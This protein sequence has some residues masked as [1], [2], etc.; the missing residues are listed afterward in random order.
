MIQNNTSPRIERKR[1]QR[2]QSLLQSALELIKQDGLAGLT[3]QKLADRQDYAVG[4]LYRYFK[5]KDALLAALQRQILTAFAEVI[6]TADQVFIQTQSD[7]HLEPK[8]QTIE[9]ARA[10][11]RL[12]L[13]SEVYFH[14]PKICPQR[15]RLLYEMTFSPQPL[16]GLHEG[17]L[18][19]Q[20]A[21]PLFKELEDRFAEAALVMALSGGTASQRAILY[22][23]SLQGLLPLEKLTRFVPGYDLPKLRT[24][25]E[26]T[27]LLGMGAQISD[28]QAARQNLKTFR[29]LPQY[30]VLF[31]SLSERTQP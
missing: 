7:K 28:L 27:L 1:E 8:T 29:T 18:V 19:L 23:S 30:H 26:N 25:L 3:M 14:L 21:L 13:A 6:H 12:L 10:L 4:A 5:S 17:L 15:F 9:R 16:L 20:V 11:T 31:E 2:I 24:E 22:W